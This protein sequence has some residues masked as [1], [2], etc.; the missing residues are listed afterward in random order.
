M[1][2][3]GQLLEVPG[4]AERMASLMCVDVDMNLDEEE[5]DHSKSND[6]EAK[7]SVSELLESEIRGAKEKGSDSVRWLELED[8]Q[9]DD[10]TLL[11]LDLPTKFP[12]FSFEQTILKYYCV[13]VVLK[14]SDI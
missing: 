14:L 3:C 13:G 8:L 10:D 7:Q 11:S 2:A 1:L 5:E 4:L 12:V 9:I 6:D